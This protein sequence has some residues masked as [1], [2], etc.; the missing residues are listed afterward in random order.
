MALVHGK[1]YQHSIRLPDG[2]VTTESYGQGPVAADFASMDGLI[3]AKRERERRELAEA[4]AGEW[5]LLEAEEDRGRALRQ[6]VAT[7]LEG[8]GFVRYARN[9]WRRRAMTTLATIDRKGTPPDRAEVRALVKA[10]EA[11]EPGALNRFR[12]A[13]R[14]HP[15]AVA[16]LVGIDLAE[17]A[18][19]NIVRCHLTGDLRREKATVDL[20]REKATVQ[21][22]AMLEQLTGPRPSPVLKLVAEAVVFAWAEHWMLSISA[23]KY[24]ASS[25]PMQVRRQ[26]AAHK[27]FM[28]SLKTY[29]QIAAL[30]GRSGTFADL[31]K[32]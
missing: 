11:G 8:F 1:Y 3:R 30:E 4:E 24:I 17:L 26:A 15:A 22:R 16:E 5:E 21:M 23:G 20:R 7:V 27:R 10:V 28:S 6:I 32:S 14:L 25:T 19:T 12:D 13:A 29:T 9:P 18:R 31:F 2:R